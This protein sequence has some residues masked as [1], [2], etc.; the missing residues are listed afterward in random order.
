MYLSEF[1][2]TQEENNPH[3]ISELPVP[4]YD[5]KKIIGIADRL[6][7][8]SISLDDI[9]PEEMG[10]TVDNALPYFNELIQQVVFPAE[11]EYLSNIND[12]NAMDL[13]ECI[14][15][16]NKVLDYGADNI[17]N[18]KLRYLLLMSFKILMMSRLKYS[19][20]AETILSDC[21]LF[22]VGDL[23]QSIYRFR[24]ARL[25]AFDQLKTYKNMIGRF[26]ILI[27]IIVRMLD[28]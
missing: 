4:I 22:V 19:K 11:I 12:R 23:K 26:I 16:L 27:L 15:L 14:I 8:K 7:Q 17:S 1:L 10:V 3:F 28:Y 18:L 20:T 9:K 13:K 6:L 25:S 21:R 5:L 24:G 2:R